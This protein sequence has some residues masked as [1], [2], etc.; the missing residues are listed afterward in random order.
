MADVFW[1]IGTSFMIANVKVQE[2]YGSYSLTISSLF[3]FDI[4]GIN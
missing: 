2:K 1:L 3:I 4:Y